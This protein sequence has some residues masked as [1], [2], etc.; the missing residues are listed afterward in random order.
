MQ[1]ALHRRPHRSPYA[2]R[3][4]VGYVAH[5]PFVYTKEASA[6]FARRTIERVQWPTEVRS[7]YDEW[8]V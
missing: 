5:P 3:S 7:K 6:N 1:L 4:L 8:R 2:L